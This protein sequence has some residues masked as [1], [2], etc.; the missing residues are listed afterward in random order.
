M[1]N[2]EEVNIGGDIKIKKSTVDFAVNAY[3]RTPSLFFRHLLWEGGVFTLEEVANSSVKGKKTV[4]SPINPRPP[5]D[6]VKFK[7]LRG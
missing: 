5:L 4:M 1:D 7:W 6:P 2:N 3:Q